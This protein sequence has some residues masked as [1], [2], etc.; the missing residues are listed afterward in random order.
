MR[1][2]SSFVE[3]KNQLNL[4][5]EAE[6]V[7][8]SETDHSHSNVISINERISANQ[9]KSRVFI[10]DRLLDFSKKLP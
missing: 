4:A 8:L 10:F 1:K 2:K 3:N 7:Q 6:A 9:L 5:F